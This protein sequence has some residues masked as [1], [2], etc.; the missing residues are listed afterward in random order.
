MTSENHYTLTQTM[1]P[2][3]RQSASFKSDWPTVEA[4]RAGAAA[5]ARKAMLITDE[6]AIARRLAPLADLAPGRRQTVDGVA[7]SITP[8]R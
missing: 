4:A 3:A 2:K 7:Y 8:I 6:S 5:K 1:N